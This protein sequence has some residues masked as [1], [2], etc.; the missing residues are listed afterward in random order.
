M[1]D[2]G[3]P[4]SETERDALIDQISEAV[5]KRGMETPAILFLEMHKPLSFFASQALI[6]SSPLLA[7]L[8]GLDRVS[9]ASS[10]LESRENVELLVRKI[11]ER[12]A[13]GAAR[14]KGEAT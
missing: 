7:P 9:A 5:V 6:V 12:A 3:Q 4:L 8:V 13:R 14:R 2:L 1:P 10:L 11:E